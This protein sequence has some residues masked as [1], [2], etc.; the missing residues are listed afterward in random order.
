MNCAPR[1]G[2]QTLQSHEHLIVDDGSTDAGSPR[3]GTRETSPASAVD[4]RQNRG[5]YPSQNELIGRAG[6]T[7]VNVI[8]ADDRFASVDVFANVAPWRQPPNRR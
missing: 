6:G 4:L 3:P 5:Q 1:Y 8:C 2:Q 7:Y